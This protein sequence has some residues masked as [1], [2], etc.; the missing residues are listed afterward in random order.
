M[1]YTKL[2]LS[3]GTKLT[4]DHLKHI[5]DGIF[6]KQ[7]PLV[8]GTNIKTINGVSI[9]GNGDLTISGDGSV[10]SSKEARLVLPDVIRWEIGKPLYIFKHA[11]ITAFNYKTYNIQVLMSSEAGN[12]KDRHRYFM[13]TPT[14]AGTITLTFKLYDN[15]QNLLDTKQ[16]IL[17]TVASTIPSS[18]TTV[19]FI[20]D[21]LTYYNR[22]TDEFYRIMTSSDSD[23]TVKDTISIYNVFKPAG[24][25]S[26]NVQLIGT[27]KLNYKGWTG[28]TYHEG[29]SGWGWGNFI[30]SGSPFYIN[31]ALNFNTYLTNKGY[32]TPDV[33][34]IGLG[35]N[36]TRNIPIDDT[37]T[38][39]TSTAYTQAKTF[40]TALTTQLP[41]AKVRLWTQNVPGTRGGI[42]NHV[43]G[44]TSW[45]DEHRT[46]LMQLAIAEMY[47]TLAAEFTNVEVVWSIAMIDSEYALQEGNSDINYRIVDDEVLGIDYV[48][49]ADSGFFQIADAIVS[50]FMHCIV[51][52]GTEVEDTR[53]TTPLTMYKTAEGNAV[54]YYQDVF[55]YFN[56]STLQSMKAQ[57][58]MVDVS[59]YIGR[60]IKITSANAVID[61]AYYAMF[62]SK[63]PTGCESLEALS[64]FTATGYEEDKTDMVNYFNVSTTNNV[65]NTIT[66][67]VPSGATYLAFTNL[68]N[69]CTE[70]SVGLIDK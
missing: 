62:T 33:I 66:V 26:G 42:G 20:G 8:S 61:G 5:E 39:D 16:V 28:Q 50:D 45:T 9:L 41:N 29:R 2:N 4:E 7:D 48:H 35:W 52:G 3:N 53:P 59:N 21:S 24:R 15:N 1:A 44:A 67:T 17:E 22:I 65:T 18:M 54:M 13:Y 23:S 70:P 57:A 36:D 12:G 27:Q 58:I 30:K 31:G 11:I 14:N 51:G 32:N 55:K 37:G 38:I 60:E 69:Y 49:P 63:L 34:Y 25:K 64:S 47:K 6:N 43:Y 68:G 40:L 19:L 56:N 10:T 46:K